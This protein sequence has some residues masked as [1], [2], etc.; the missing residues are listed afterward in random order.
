MKYLSK[1][2]QTYDELCESIFDLVRKLID[3]GTDLS[4]IKNIVNK[5]VK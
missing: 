4:E 1:L 3:L 2:L 5:A